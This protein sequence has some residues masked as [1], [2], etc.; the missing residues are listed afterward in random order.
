MIEELTEIIDELIY[1]TRF[2][3]YEGTNNDE[4]KKHK[5]NLKKLNKKIEK[6]EISDCLEIDECDIE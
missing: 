4:I 3:I 5:K 2:I 1:I 6:G